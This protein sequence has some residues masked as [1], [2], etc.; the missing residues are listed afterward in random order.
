M[1]KRTTRKQHRVVIIQIADKRVQILPRF[2]RCCCIRTSRLVPNLTDHAVGG[3]QARIP[4]D[5]RSF[6]FT[7]HIFNPLH[8]A[9]RVFNPHLIGT[10]VEIRAI[11]FRDFGEELFEAF[12]EHLSSFLRVHRE[13]KGI[14][15]ISGMT[16]HVYFGHYGDASFLRV[17][18]DF[19]DFIVSVELALVATF[20]LVLWII[21]L[22]I[23]LTFDAPSGIVGQMPVEIIQLIEAHQVQSLFQHAD[24]LI[25]APR[26]VHEAPKRICC[27]VVHLQVGNHALFVNQL[28]Q[29]AFRPNHI[30]RNGGLAP[31]DDNAIL[32]GARKHFIGFNDFP[33]F[34]FLR[35]KLLKFFRFGD[36][37]G[38]GVK[39]MV[40]DVVHPQLDGQFG[41]VDAGRAIAPQLGIQN[42]VIVMLAEGELSVDTF[43][44][45]GISEGTL[46]VDEKDEAVLKT[47]HPIRVVFSLF[48]GRTSRIRRAV[49]LLQVVG[50]IAVN[51]MIHIGISA[52]MLHDVDFAGIRPV[53]QLVG[54]G[55]HPNGRPKPL[56]HI[57]LRPNL[58][59]SEAKS[60]LVSG[61][62]A[63]RQKWCRVFGQEIVLHASQHEVA[64]VEA[65]QCVVRCH[66]NGPIGLAA[67]YLSPDARVQ[68]A[69][70]EF[71][72][73]YQGITPTFLRVRIF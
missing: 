61:P 5:G 24:R 9:L 8:K 54:L 4:S 26:V 57:E 29:R 71:I 48:I 50:V 22:R 44:I 10:N 46:A 32:I 62:H 45:A 59:A 40:T 31:P 34:V 16:R 47:F 36:D 12:F 63:T 19:T 7:Y 66:V 60:L 33:Q 38:L 21:E 68:G 64:V 27:P 25:V 43:P 51:R 72:V 30:A 20:A 70:I 39:L 14:L 67:P 17:S 1:Q 2:L 65:I 58:N 42:Q 53:D 69:R 6:I 3:R 37:V 11:A 49:M 23:S 55:L 73:P 28:R 52:K 13:A 56:R 15:E 18:D 41:R 35:S